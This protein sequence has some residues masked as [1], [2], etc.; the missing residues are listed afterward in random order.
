MRYK[1]EPKIKIKGSDN[2]SLINQKNTPYLTSHEASYIIEVDI[3][4]IAHNRNEKSM[5]EISIDGQQFQ[6]SEEI[7]LKVISPLRGNYLSFGTCN[8]YCN[9]ISYSLCYN[10][11]ILPHAFYDNEGFGTIP[12]SYTHLT[13]PTICSV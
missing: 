8:C 12:V 2:V 7:K 3:K 5:L 11:Q 10:D 9:D 6:W 4:S 1:E 13:L